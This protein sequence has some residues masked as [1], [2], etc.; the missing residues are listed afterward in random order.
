[1][2]IPKSFQLF[3]NTIEVE[4]ND[5]RMNEMNCYGLTEPS[6]S[7][8]SLAITNDGHD[9]SEDIK[10]DTYYHERTHAILWEM[11]EV[12]LYENEKFVDIFSKLLRQSEN[13]TKY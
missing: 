10:I 1:M 4:I 7:L 9:L 3:A 13:T 12:D 6:K 8:I 5:K 11:G 2:K